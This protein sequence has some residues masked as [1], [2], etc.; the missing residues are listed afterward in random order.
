LR[1]TLGGFVFGKSQPALYGP[2]IVLIAES[3]A[4][5]RRRA[6]ACV[7]AHGNASRLP[8]RLRLKKRW[9]SVLPFS[10]QFSPQHH[11]IRNRHPR[12]TGNKALRTSLSTKQGRNHANHFRIHLEPVTWPIPCCNGQAGGRAMIELSAAILGLISVAIFAA[13]AVDAYRTH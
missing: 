10:I 8:H 6:Q 2:I 5:R 4:E 12:I 13:H 9:P 11:R 1:S 3:A 7:I